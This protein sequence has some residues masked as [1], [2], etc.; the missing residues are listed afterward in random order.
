MMP[1]RIR[2]ILATFCTSAAISAIAFGLFLSA[3]SAWADD[4]ITNGPVCY[5]CNYQTPDGCW[6]PDPYFYACGGYCENGSACTDCECITVE[7]YY[8]YCLCTN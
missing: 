8:N 7:S 6:S 3:S 1:T 2:A 5:D 4:P